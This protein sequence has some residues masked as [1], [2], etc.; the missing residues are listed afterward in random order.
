MYRIITLFIFQFFLLSVAFGQEYPVIKSYG[1]IYDIPN[2]DE[3]PDKTLI[4]NIVIDVKYKS[5]PEEVNYGLE[6]IARMVNLHALGGV[7]MKNMNVVVA[8]HGSSTMSILSNAAYQKKYGIDNPNIPLINELV[9]A[10]IKLYVCGQ[11]LKAR[12]VHV[13]DVYGE[14][15]KSL[16]ALTILTTYQLR[17]YSLLTFQ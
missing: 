11:S 16:S 7:E 13:E 12:N 4:Y 17:G 5:K 14:V 8:I 1:G 6:N 10:G 9:A 3:K 15:G 2:P